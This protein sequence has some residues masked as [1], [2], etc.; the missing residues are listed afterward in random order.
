MPSLPKKKETT[1]LLL[2]ALV[3]IGGLAT[4]VAYPRIVATKISAITAG[5]E[6]SPDSWNGRALHV[7]GVVVDRGEN[8][9]ELA[10]GTGTIDAKWLGTL[11]AIGTSNVL[12][13]GILKVETFPFTQVKRVE[14]LADS[15]AVWPV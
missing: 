1:I 10:D 4:Y 3:V 11:P 7:F 9:V 15:L 2:L 6:T 12:V 14:L 5:V 13:H 8:D